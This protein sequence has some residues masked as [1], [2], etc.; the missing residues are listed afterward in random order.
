MTIVEVDMNGFWYG[1]PKKYF[2]KD[3]EGNLIVLTKK[4]Y[5]QMMVNGEVI[6]M[7]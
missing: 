4:E 1:K 3:A 2:S 6:A 7:S 5:E